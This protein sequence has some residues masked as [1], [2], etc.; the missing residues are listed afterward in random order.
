MTFCCSLH[1]P[2]LSTFALQSV[3]KELEGERS[4][5]SK[6]LE[7]AKKRLAKATKAQHSAEMA[8]A[9]VSPAAV[10]TGT[11]ELYTFLFP[12][13]FHYW[14]PYH[15]YHP[16]HDRPEERQRPNAMEGSWRPHS[17]TRWVWILTG[18][19]STSVSVVIGILVCCHQYLCLLSFGPSVSV[20]LCSILRPVSFILHYHILQFA[21]NLQPPTSNLLGT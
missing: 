16:S 5:F 6:A 2:H 11:T 19:I 1:R 17:P 8:L 20:V 15:S 9:E 4:K 21:L 13:M 14:C 10:R 7:E 3:R 18:I 12:E